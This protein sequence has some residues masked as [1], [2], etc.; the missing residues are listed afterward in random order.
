MRR[1]IL[2]VLAILL[3]ASF[4]AAQRSEGEKNSLRGLSG[5]FVLVETVTEDARRQG[6]DNNLL[7]TDVELRLRKASIHIASQTEL[8]QSDKIGV[9]YINV[10]TTQLKDGLFV[11]CENID[12][13]QSV[14]LARDNSIRLETATTYRINETF[15]TFPP[16]RLRDG[17]RS[18][19]NDKVDAF[20]SDY[21]A[22]NQR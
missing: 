15:G 14:R 9:L 17:V 3:L 8:I 20:I 19:I 22:V 12:L 10:G 7:Q 1:S 5:I 4:A 16:S 13:R 18:L 11:V 2:I 6:L 21:L